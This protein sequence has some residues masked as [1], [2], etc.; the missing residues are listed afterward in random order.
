MHRAGIS[1]AMVRLVHSYLRQ[2][3]FKVKLEGQLSTVRTATAGV[4]QGS[5]ISPL[6]FS[7]Y[8]SDIPATASGLQRRRHGNSAEFTFIPFHSLATT[9][10]ISGGHI[11]FS[12]ELASAHTSRL[13]SRTSNVW[14]PLSVTDQARQA[15]SLLRTQDLLEAPS[16]TVTRRGPPG[17]IAE[18]PAC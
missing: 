11:G 5:A 2:R 18:H 4:P 16:T 9:D 1:K 8:T 7:I 14:N 12:S 3:A 6:L 13:R 15:R 17:L 10:Q